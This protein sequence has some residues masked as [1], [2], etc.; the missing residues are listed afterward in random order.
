MDFRLR[1][2]RVEFLD[3]DGEIVGAVDVTQATL[4]EE[5]TLG[6]M[7]AEAKDRNDQEIV[8]WIAEHGDEPLPTKLQKRQNFRLAIYPKMAA[9]SSGDV[10]N[11]E[12]AHKMPASELNKW[13]NAAK[14][15]NPDWFRI[16]DEIEAILSREDNDPEKESLL[17]KKGRKRGE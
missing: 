10:L 3:S 17:Q 12:E 1:T 2:K 14:F 4:G 6:E 8:Q 15:C 5:E 11:E 16:F 7:E 13:Y 9:C